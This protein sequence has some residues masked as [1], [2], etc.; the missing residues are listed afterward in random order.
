MATLGSGH[1]DRKYDRDFLLS[2]Q[3]RNQLIELWEVEKYGRDCFNDPD[4]V[5]LYGM[6][7]KE[8]YERGV[9][10]LARTCLEAVKDPLGN[11]IGSDIA[12]VVARAPGNRAIGVVDPFAGSCNGL[13]AI[14]RHLPGANGIGFEI[15]PAVFDLTTRNIAHL[16]APIELVHGSY[17]YF[18]GSNDHAKCVMK[19]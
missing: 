10:I 1:S 18:V 2:A 5:H 6:A 13:Y 16:D 3:K 9:R 7:P 8:W 15:E 4:H 17:K 11:K 19:A 14:L 12:E